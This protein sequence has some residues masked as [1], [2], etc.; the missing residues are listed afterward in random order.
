VQSLPPTGQKTATDYFYAACPVV[1]G[2]RSSVT[3][4]VR[5]KQSSRRASRLDLWIHAAGVIDLRTTFHL[6][7][8][9]PLPYTH[10]SCLARFQALLIAFRVSMLVG[11]ALPKLKI[12]IG[13]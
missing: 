6:S 10:Y 11:N 13:C 1:N 3:P 7:S 5:R 9:V 8:D 2:I 4:S 12:L